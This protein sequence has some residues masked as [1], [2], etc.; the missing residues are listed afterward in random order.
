M[1][2][3]P[4]ENRAIE[5]DRQSRNRDLISQ[6][7]GE[8]PQ[9]YAQFNMIAHNGVDFAIPE[10]TPIFA[11]CDGFCKVMNHP[12]GYGLH[13]KQRSWHSP[14]ELVYGHLSKVVIPFV[15]EPVSVNLG[16]LIG[17]SGNTGFSTGPHLHFGLRF[18]E[19]NGQDIWQW[20]VKSYRNGYYGYVNPAEYMATWKGSLTK[21]NILD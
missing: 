16:D 7:F 10:G 11:A 2:I 12:K 20:Y 19:P 5:G 21:N 3:S 1:L 4:I 9:I 13:I 6:G 15:G 17:F 14:K 8:N 18:L